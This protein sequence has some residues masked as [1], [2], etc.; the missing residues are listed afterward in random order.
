MRRQAGGLLHFLPRRHLECYL[1]DPAAMAAFIVSKD[2]ASADNVTPQAVEAALKAAA[3]ERPLFVSEWNE[4]ITDA[5]W[6]ARSDAANL[7]VAV[8]GT[9][10]E[11]R[12]PFVKKNDSLFLLKH[13]LEHDPMR[14][15]PLQDYLES[16]IA[17]VE[18]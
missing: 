7:I 17:A 9:L 6:L 3:R 14:L 5:N 1:L 4:N 2:P 12:A 18:V 11:H 16:L 10:S 13:M 8:C 15:R